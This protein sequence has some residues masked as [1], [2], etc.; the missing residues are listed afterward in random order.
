MFKDILYQTDPMRP[1]A[2]EKETAEF[3]EELDSEIV[4]LHA[5][6]DVIEK[7]LGAEETML[8]AKTSL[9]GF[10]DGVAFSEVSGHQYSGFDRLSSYVKVRGPGM[11]YIETVKDQQLGFD[12]L[13]K[14]QELT[15]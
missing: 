2:S 7:T 4:I 1:L 6:E 5:Q 14:A 8:V 13:F 9:L 15:R 10:E 12:Q 3:D 11:I